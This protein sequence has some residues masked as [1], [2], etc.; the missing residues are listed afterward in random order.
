MLNNVW[1][2]SEALINNKMRQKFSQGYK[3]DYLYQKIVADL[4][5]NKNV[6]NASKVGHP[7]CLV[8]K[9][10]YNIA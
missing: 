4:I 1:F 6:A 2:A 7:F 10:L 5:S 9:L 3:T 8:N